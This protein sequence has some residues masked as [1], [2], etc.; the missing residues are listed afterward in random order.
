MTTRVELKGWI[1]AKHADWNASPDYAFFQTR[2]MGEY[3]YTMICAHTLA[4]DLPDEMTENAIAI[5][6]C[7]SERDAAGRKYQ[8]TVARCNDRLSKLRAITNEVTT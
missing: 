8:E 2:D 7:E 3:G 1:Q 4:F 6:T 5:K